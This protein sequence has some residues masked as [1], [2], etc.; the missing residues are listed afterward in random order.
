MESGVERKYIDEWLLD[1]WVRIGYDEQVRTTW[2]EEY[3]HVARH[4]Q[5]GN[6][7]LCPKA[8]MGSTK[9][10]NGGWVITSL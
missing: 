10:V 4:R 8:S 9:H 6:E 7:E 1:F 3:I 5:V 2:K